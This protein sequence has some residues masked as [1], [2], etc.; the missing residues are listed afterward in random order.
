MRTYVY[1]SKGGTDTD[2]RARQTINKRPLNTRLRS[3]CNGSHASN[4]ACYF[5]GK[6]SMQLCL[7]AI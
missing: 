4:K 3:D 2:D 1:L 5:F 6:I 7:S